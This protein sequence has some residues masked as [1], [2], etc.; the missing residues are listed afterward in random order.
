MSLL[1]S[2][3]C[4]QKKAACCLTL[5]SSGFRRGLFNKI[6]A[7][8]V[9]HF[10]HFRKTQ[11]GLLSNYLYCTYGQHSTLTLSEAHHG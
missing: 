10:L 6:N 4:F 8:R 2:M 3:L 11:Q 5:P 9:S 1:D 7:P